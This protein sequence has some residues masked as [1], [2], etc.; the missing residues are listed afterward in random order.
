MSMIQGTMMVGRM[1]CNNEDVSYNIFIR[2]QLIELP[3]RTYNTKGIDTS[4]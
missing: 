1:G 2:N 3:G 4:I